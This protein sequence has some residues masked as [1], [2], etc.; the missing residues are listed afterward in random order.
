MRLHTLE[1]E[2][3]GPYATRQRIDFSRLA[4]SGLFLLEGPTG[5]GKTTILDA[6]TFALY[7]GLAG[8][9]SAG[10]RLR[11]H[12]APPDAEPSVTLEFSIGG[13]RHRVHRSP[14]YQRP[15]RRGGGFTVQH[16]QVHLER[17]S[18]NRWT[19]LSANK[20][21]AGELITEI[22]GLNRDQFTQVMLLPQG[23]FATFLRSSDDDRRAL[24]TRLFR[25]QLYDRIT[26]EL[27]RGKQEAT[28]ARKAAHEAIGNCVSAAAEAA[29]LDAAARGE[30][31]AAGRTDRATWLKEF[32]AELAQTIEVS[33]AGLEIAV[34]GLTGAQQ[35]E[36]AARRQAELMTRL[37][38]ALGRL[39][40]HEATRPGH[41]QL[42]AQLTAARQAEPVR[43]LLTALDEAEQVCRAAQTSL[44]GVTAVL[45]QELDEWPG[46]PAGVELR[47]WLVSRHGSDGAA[48]AGAAGAGAAPAGA[49]IAPGDPGADGGR[50]AAAHAAA[51]AAWAEDGERQAAALEHLV[52]A[53]AA[54]PAAEEVLAGLR[55]A[56]EAAATRVTTLERSRDE[57]PARIT[58]LQERL[59]GAR[60]AAA[61]LP[62]A[63][64]QQA[65]AE[66]QLAAAV[67]AEELRDQLAELEAARQAAIDAHQDAV[68]AHQRA[69]EERLE[70]M[71]AELAER[72]ADGG[73][74]PVCGST[75]HPGPAAHLADAVSAEDVDA[76]ASRRD[77]AA[78][79]RDQAQQARDDVAAEASEASAVAGGATS[80]QMEAALAERSERVQV[81]EQAAAEE[82]QLGPAADDLRA[83]QEQLAEELVDATGEVAAARQ[84]AGDVAVEL[85]RLAAELDTAAAGFGSVADREQALQLAAVASRSL[86]QALGI[87]AEACAG[88]HAARLRAER[89]LTASGL[90]SLSAARAAVLPVAGQ[91]R[92]TAQAAEWE[93]AMARLTAAASTDE[94]TDLDPGQAAAAAAAAHAAAA[95]LA[96][97]QEAER[98]ARASYQDLTRRE[99]RLGQRMAELTAAEEAADRTE[100][101]TGPVIRLAGLARGMDG[102]RRIALT[103]YV[104]RRW[105]E[106]VVQA[107]NVR[108]AAMSA[109]RYELARTEEAESRRQRTGL[110]LVVIDRHTGEERSPRSLSGGETFYTSLALALGLADVVRAEAGGVELD[111]LFID[112]GFGTLD[113]QTLDQVMTV[114]DELRDRGRAVGIVSHVTDLKDRVYERLEV[115]RLPDGSS[116]ATVVA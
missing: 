90:T 58:V 110:T 81:A 72:L 8:S 54:R 106:Q 47:A 13:V 30:L 89:E 11:S 37:T 43:P 69:M 114:I 23:E 41:E 84:K 92:L 74:C 70:N 51:A 3:I 2:A 71:A 44:A 15:K 73:P 93:S 33:R 111:T 88:E 64:E 109:G 32:S 62:Q 22:V 105:F 14:E 20:A 79:Q 63:R 87:L 26:S 49:G 67:R 50:A 34:T 113:G 31:L 76:A 55:A 36:A 16:A 97:A 99:E 19:S 6:L 112:E 108:L 12:F 1:L 82:Q 45:D 115:R 98:L 85:A 68:D 65:A 5:A 7:G 28:Q 83:E 38:A 100:E 101:E 116:A 103:T 59:D 66:A 46:G 52:A 61:A 42:M 60:A 4:A 25:T 53:E 10:D 18:D 95:D 107:A 77:A 104:L 94:L 56:A 27:E 48:G 102:H 24:L 9:D 39:A 91:A 86:A 75:D 29:G 80:G 35:A 17:R 78:Q 21:E 57:L 96:A 40:A